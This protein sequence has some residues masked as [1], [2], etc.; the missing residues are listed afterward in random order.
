MKYI[1]VDNDIIDLSSYQVIR[2]NNYQKD[3]VDHY[4]VLFLLAPDA[5][6]AKYKL[7]FNSEMDQENF[8]EFIRTEL[9]VTIYER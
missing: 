9:T 4:Q 7:D 8:L 3:G 6:F 5:E 1:Q 2:K